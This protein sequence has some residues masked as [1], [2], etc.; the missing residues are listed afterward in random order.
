M[1]LVE[2]VMQGVRGFSKLT[3]IRFQGGFNFILGGNES[4]KTSSVDSI[5]RLLFPVNDPQKTGSFVPRTASDASRGAIV[6]FADDQ[7]YYQIIQDFSKRAVNLSKHDPA[8][9]KFVLLHKDW[10]SS[11]QLMS[12]FLS[13][14]SEEDYERLFVF[15]RDSSAGLSVFPLQPS[16]AT[17]TQKSS[18]SHAAAGGRSAAQEA[19]LS[20]LRDVLRKAE[21][22]A[23]A[24]YKAE[25]ARLKLGEI[26]KKLERFSEFNKQI[27]EID[28]Q[29]AELSA[30]ETLPENIAELIAAHEQEQSQ[31]IVK[32]TELDN[33][34]EGLTLQ[35]DAIPPANLV[36]DKLFIAGA[37]LGGL[38]LIAG[39]FILSDEQAL[40]FPLG[41]LA[42]LFLIAG[43]WYNS[44]RKNAQRREIQ[45]EIDAL[46]K[47]RAEIEKK[48]QESG[49][50]ILKFMKITGATSAAQLKEKADT[51]RHLL[52]LRSDLDEQ[53]ALMFSGQNVEDIQAEYAKQQEEVAALE[54]AAKA[55]AHHAVD[56]YS[57]RQEIERIE[58]DTP[59]I[60]AGADVEF[61]DLVMGGAFGAAADLPAS[62][63]VNV[64]AEI[65]VASR[66]SGIEMETLVPAVESA[67]QRNLVGASGGRYV[68]IE[69]C[70]DGRPAVHD[71]GGVRNEYEELSHGM[72]QVVYFCLRAGI[73]E[74]IAGKRRLPFILD[75][76]FAGLD[77]ARQAAACQVLRL[78]G[79]KT[80]VILFASNP[81]L[82]APNDVG[83][84]LK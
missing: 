4:G 39:L 58:G 25:A 27:E 78:L 41:V 68:K 74:S 81:A 70:P 1:F 2:L 56:T 40:F 42:S 26:S 14:L 48:F 35:R 75:D 17:T 21:E 79:T 12:G 60:G 11:A 73:V 50:E 80:Q 72:R 9:K 59:S 84:E 69:V 13:G 20:E 45:K 28:A 32:T 24:E 46:V 66:V 15:R 43:G 5:I 63:G 76:P 33:D 16:A 3:R 23:D 83:A 82:K 38:A 29:L 61:A 64:L 53:K 22:A 10:I 51:Y 30:C 37:A 65:A 44:S 18:R 7:A 62:G 6:V 19:R 55:V 52:S 71:A 31:K 77:P 57:I 8:T 36:A 54:Q 49:S 67:A 47:E 34:I